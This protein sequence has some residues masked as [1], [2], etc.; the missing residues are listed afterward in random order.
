MTITLAIVAAC[1]VAAF[2]WVI[3]EVIID[4]R[5]DY[6]EDDHEQ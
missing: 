2:I 6:L 1:W 4:Y 5:P 3:D